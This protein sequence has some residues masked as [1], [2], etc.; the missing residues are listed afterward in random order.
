MELRL[1]TSEINH[2]TN[3]WCRQKGIHARDL[4]NHPQADD[5]VLLINFRSEFWDVMTAQEQGVWAA[6]WGWTYTKACSLK[7]KH[8]DKLQKIGNSVIFRKEK[9]A[10][11][12]A[13]IKAMRAKAQ[14]KTTSS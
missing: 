10:Q 12:Q 11:R 14:L 2:Y 13:T 6:Y 7:R 1:S 5:V 8:L 4:E 9:Q 3:M